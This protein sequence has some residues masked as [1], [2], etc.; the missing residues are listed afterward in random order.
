MLKTSINP[1]TFRKK[2]TLRIRLL[3]ASSVLFGYFRL[4]GSLIHFPSFLEDIIR[5]ESEIIEILTESLKNKDF[6]IL[7]AIIKHNFYHIIFLAIID[8]L[9]LLTQ[10]PT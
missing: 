1:K 7:L 10:V 6:I 3:N 5:K 8:T 4:A 9:P 2:H